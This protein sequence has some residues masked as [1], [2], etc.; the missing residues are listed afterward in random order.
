MNK[1]TIMISTSTFIHQ[2]LL[3]MR[4]ELPVILYQKG[5]ILIKPTSCIGDRK[6]LKTLM[7][8]GWVDHEQCALDYGEK[9]KNVM[10]SFQRDYMSKINC[11]RKIFC[12]YQ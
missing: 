9:A 8:K 3:D 6:T 1:A 12:S 10:G 7:P 11:I 4:E 5:E 2:P